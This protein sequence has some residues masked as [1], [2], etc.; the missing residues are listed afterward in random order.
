MNTKDIDDILLKDDF[1]KNYFIGTMAR[2]QFIAILKDFVNKSGMIIFNT[3]ELSKKGE[4]W[5]GFFKGEK[6]IEFFDSF[7]RSLDNFPDIKQQ[8][9]TLFPNFKVEYN[10]AILQ[11]ITTTVCGDYCM[12]YCLLRSRF[13]TFSQIINV[14]KN[15]HNTEI[16]DHSIRR[17]FLNNYKHISLNKNKNR[18]IT[19]GIDN[20]HIQGVL[21]KTSFT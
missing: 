16:R 17:M 10:S 6:Q 13:W 5:I 8:L 18:N 1:S 7:G 2:D 4:H 19:S 14:L 11:G 21:P 9:F 20:V 15:I 3:D 12:F